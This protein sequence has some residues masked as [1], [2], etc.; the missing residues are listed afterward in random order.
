MTIGEKHPLQHTNQHQFIWNNI[1][2]IMMM[3]YCWWCFNLSHIQSFEMQLWLPNLRKW[4]QHQVITIS[5]ATNN[6]VTF[7][8]NII[9]CLS[10]W[11]IKLSAVF[12]SCHI[13]FFDIVTY[14]F[15]IV[16]RCKHCDLTLLIVLGSAPLT[17]SIS[18]K[19]QC[20]LSQ[21]M[22]KASFP[23]YS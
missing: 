21:A 19:F 1:D 9:F 3:T 12:P 10:C 6:I 15:K 17:S 20:P 13:K 22:F 14:G 8:L 18:A 7:A 23:C 5:I 4:C 2:F 11:I 16:H